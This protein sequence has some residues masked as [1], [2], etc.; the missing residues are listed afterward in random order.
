MRSATVVVYTYQR[1]STCRKAVQ[2][3]RESGVV[4]AERPIMEQPPSSA[5]LRR[6][7]ELQRGEL[8]R[9]FN[10]SGLEYRAQNLATK[11]PALGVEET[12][13]LLAGNGRLVKRPFVLGPD[14]GLL[15]FDEA[16]WA[17]VAWPKL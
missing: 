12:L 4:F 6:M 8:R 17:A 9:L 11:L 10:T 14:F 15:G 5:E 7:L 1:C 3:L 2:W 13:A 16:K